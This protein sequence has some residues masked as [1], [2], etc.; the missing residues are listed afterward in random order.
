[1]KFAFLVHP[2]SYASKAL[3]EMNDNGTLTNHWGG[4]FLEFC[5][6]LHRTMAARRESRERND[7]PRVRVIDQLQQLR[8]VTGATTEGRVYEIPMGA[9]EI[10]D[11]PARA[12]EYM[13]QVWAS[14]ACH[15]DSLTQTSTEVREQLIGGTAGS[16]TPPSGRE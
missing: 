6:F 4:D 11:S 3:L 9:A 2:L 1:M 10:V 13:Q 16:P 8:S 7:P 5:G 12:L 15:P 14:G